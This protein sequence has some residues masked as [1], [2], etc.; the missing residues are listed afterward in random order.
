MFLPTN[1][2]QA[3]TIPLFMILT[4]TLHYPISREDGDNDITFHSYPVVTAALLLCLAASRLGRG[5]FGLA[6]TQ[7]AQARVPDNVRASFAGVEFGLGQI[8][9]LLH[10]IA[11]AVYSH[12]K[13]YGWMSCVSFL[14]VCSSACLYWT[15]FFRERR[16]EEKRAGP[17]AIE[18]E[19]LRVVDAGTSE[20][21]GT[22]DE[23]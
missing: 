15:W 3:P 19:N 12:P 6:T 22:F 4:T 13:D 18:E 2:L 16:D 23:T 20:A 7:L 17:S 14:A 8:F 11:T 21:Y 5:I 9:G 1:R 10:N